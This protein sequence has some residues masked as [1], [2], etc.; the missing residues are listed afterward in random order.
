MNGLRMVGAVS[1]AMM[2]VG[3]GAEEEPKAGTAENAGGEASAKVVT[4]SSGLVGVGGVSP[5]QRV[6]SDAV[7]SAL[8]ARAPKYGEATPE[9]MKE[10]AAPPKPE[11]PRNGILRLKS[12]VVLGDKP[13][14]KFTPKDLLSPRDFRHYLVEKYI[15]ELDR[16]ILNRWALFGSVEGRAMQMYL[17][18][19]RLE[20]IAGLK[21][22]ADNAALAGDKKQSEYIRRL[23]EETFMRTIAWGYT[24]AGDRTRTVGATH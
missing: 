23:S 2:A 18:D 21:E 10:G 13:L 12:L 5:R 4:I 1:V 11:E 15:S 6:I 17:E 20:D 8:T 14:P 19:K 3:L 22:D 9:E 7:A 16:G 24:A